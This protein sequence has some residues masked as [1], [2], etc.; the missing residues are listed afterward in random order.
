MT[1]L[2]QTP[3]HGLRRTVADRRDGTLDLCDGRQNGRNVAS[4]LLIDIAQTSA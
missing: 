3:G 1:V 2:L 4:F